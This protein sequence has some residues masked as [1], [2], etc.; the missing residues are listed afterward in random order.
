MISN[1][2]CIQ[3]NWHLVKWCFR[4]FRHSRIEVLQVAKVFAEADTQ[5]SR[6]ECLRA[7]NK[8]SF[9]P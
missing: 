6:P 3:N 7:K 8:T 5:D 1:L 4:Q 2:L 9:S